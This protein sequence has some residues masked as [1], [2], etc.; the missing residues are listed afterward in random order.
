MATQLQS[1]GTYDNS[2]DSSVVTSAS[3]KLGLMKV[4]VIVPYCLIA[5]C[6]KYT[7][8]KF[9]ALKYKKVTDTIV[10]CMVR[11]LTYNELFKGIT[12]QRGMFFLTS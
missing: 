6:L 1:S 3:Y 12:R 10:E 8:R 7:S 2:V 11:E 5:D 4:C 9:L